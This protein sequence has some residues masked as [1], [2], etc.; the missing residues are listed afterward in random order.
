MT[1]GKVKT[2]YRFHKLVFN[3]GDSSL[4]T[5]PYML[6]FMHLKLLKGFVGGLIAS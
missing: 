5:Y 3:T 1:T 4:S 2:I 6:V